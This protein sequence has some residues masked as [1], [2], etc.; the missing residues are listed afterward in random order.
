MQQEAEEN[1]RLEEKRLAS[2]RMAQRKANKRKKDHSSK[3][4]QYGVY[5]Y[6]QSFSVFNTW[7]GD[8]QYVKCQELVPYYYVYK[9]GLYTW[10]CRTALISGGATR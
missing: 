10:I 3:L 5:S 9:R 8:I 4:H 6:I 7:T 1:V 2:A